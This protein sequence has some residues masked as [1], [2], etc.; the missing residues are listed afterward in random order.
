MGTL[1][2]WKWWSPTSGSPRG[3]TSR[4]APVTN[5]VKSIG[6][7]L[8]IMKRLYGTLAAADFGPRSYSTRLALVPWDQG[9]NRRCRE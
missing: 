5:E 9:S 2:S 1:S 4:T 7:A 8:K 6:F 3:T